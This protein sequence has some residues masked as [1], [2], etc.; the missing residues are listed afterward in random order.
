MNETKAKKDGAAALPEWEAA[1][2][3]ELE[4]RDARLLAVY[5]VY[6]GHYHRDC[7][8]CQV[9]RFLRDKHGAFSP[10]R[11]TI[12]RLLIKTQS[13]ESDFRPTGD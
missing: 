1:L 5:E 8:A 3:R 9:F 2:R 11:S 10:S 6:A 7:S 4:R 13:L 12:S